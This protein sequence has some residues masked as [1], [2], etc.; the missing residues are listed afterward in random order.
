ME[1]AHDMTFRPGTMVKPHERIDRSQRDAIHQS[2]MALLGDPGITCPNEQAVDLFEKG[3]CG[4]TKGAGG[5]GWTVRIPEKVIRNTLDTVPSRIVLGAREPCNALLLDAA[6][7]R[8][9]F[10]TGSETN[11]FLE[12]EPDQSGNPVFRAERG[13]VARLCDSAGVCNHLDNVD[14]FIRNVNAQDEQITLSNKDVN[15]FLACLAH[16]SK[17]V[18]A[19]LTDIR[20]L[21]PVVRMAE[22][23]AGGPERL[24]E[25]PI[26]SFI[27]CPVKSPLQMVDDTAEK[28]IAIC[29]TGLPLVISSSPQGGSTAPI[30]EEGIAAL[31]NAEILAG[32][33]LGQ[34]ANPGAPVLY[35]AVP[36][37][38]RLDT[39]HDLY[40]APEFIHYNIIC[41]QLARGYGI[42]CYSSA[43]VGDAPVPG[44]MA[45]TEKLL[46][47][48]S[49]AQ[50]GAQYIHYAFGL[51]DKTNTFCP[52]Q[53]II[54]DANIGQIRNILRPST[55]G[56]EDA[57]ASVNEIRKVMQS[58]MRL[59]ARGIRKQ[60]R[61][62]V[63]SPPYALE[64]DGSEHDV[65]KNAL[66]KLAAIRAASNGR[67]SDVTIDVIREEITGL[68]P[69][70]HFSPAR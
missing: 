2:S 38:A 54:D 32:I 65:L 40:G 19:G 70:H 45:S 42:P 51:L 27:A 3:G 11:V 67:L 66:G 25:N 41:A 14:F 23:V 48:L 9:Y 21:G 69:A 30:Q 17:H 6:V 61:R 46:S 60:R 7:P 4:I 58:G 34:L 39:L 53:A 22:I 57:R 24:R 52:L 20:A 59:F 64:G 33:T 55:F 44:L 10:G 63:V 28:V 50:A 13:S 56:P 68:L 18:Q 31:I 35:G 62:G 5:D 36:V 16:M 49:V 37:R 47:Q 29:R 15:V 43:G 1:T 12:C 8:V 26:I